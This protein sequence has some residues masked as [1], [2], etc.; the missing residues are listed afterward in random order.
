MNT[1]TD[2]Q[3]KHLKYRANSFNPAAS[4][5]DAERR[6]AEAVDRNPEFFGAEDH[7]HTIGAVKH[8]CQGFFRIKGDIIVTHRSGRSQPFTTVTVRHPQF[9]NHLS[10][11]EK[12]RLYYQPLQDLGVEI[13]VTAGCN[14]VHRIR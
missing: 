6:S 9:P 12:Q 8:I 10:H 5:I 14:R 1:H 2:T 4:V 3:E 11:A 13:V 7:Q